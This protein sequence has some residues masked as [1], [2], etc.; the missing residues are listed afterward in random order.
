MLTV[1]KKIVIDKKGKT[2]EVIIPWKEFKEIEELLGLDFDRNALEDIK[3]AKM[4]RMKGKKDAY[5]D[6]DA[7][8]ISKNGRRLEMI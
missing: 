8:L 2:T 6:L 7:I 3:Q 5:V 1:H 4:D